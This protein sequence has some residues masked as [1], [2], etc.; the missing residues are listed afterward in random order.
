MIC[1][2]KNKRK[3]VIF[4]VLSVL[5][6]AI[7][8]AIPF[9]VSLLPKK[10]TALSKDKAHV[11]LLCGQSNATGQTLNSYLKKNV[12][13]D[14]YNEYKNGYKNVLINYSVDPA[15]PHTSDYKFVP[16]ALG[17]GA[18]D[19]RFGPEI[20]IASY[21][22]KHFPD[23]KFYIVKVSQSGSG[24]N[25]HWAENSTPYR[26]LTRE[27]DTIFESFEEMG[28]EPEIFALCWMQGE[29]DAM[30]EG[31]ARGYYG[32]QKD[33]FKRLLDKYSDYAIDS[34]VTTITAGISDYW[35]YHELVNDAKK[36]YAKDGKNRYHFDTQRLKLTYK[37]ENDDPAHYDSLSMIK[38]GE[39]FG[40][41][42]GKAATK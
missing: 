4:G 28:L 3:F 14:K 12:D 10:A 40:K 42:I 9:V 27:M 30:G 5:L 32:L 23:E 21:L 29:T 17:Q 1:L 34:G 37:L 6:V 41:Y 33:L 24:I 18:D 26:I 16:V 38:L 39:T 31:T 36:Q 22:T 2:L 25:T 35:E 20:G 8:V 13:S 15:P 19:N 11:I 7:I